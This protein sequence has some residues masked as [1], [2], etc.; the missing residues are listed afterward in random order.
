MEMVIAERRS[1]KLIVKCDK[2]RDVKYHGDA[3]TLAHAI[4]LIPAS[5]YISLHC[6]FLPVEI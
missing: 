5:F 4:N 1:H 2:L 3:L 6:P